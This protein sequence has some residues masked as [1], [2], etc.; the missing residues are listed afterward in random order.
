M[1][2]SFKNIWYTFSL[3]CNYFCTEFILF[4]IY[5]GWIFAQ[6]IESPGV[7]QKIC[8][9][10]YNESNIVDCT[11][12]EDGDVEDEIQ[13]R[14]AQWYLYT[15]LAYMFPA[16]FIDTILGSYADKYGRKFNIL[17][18][19]VGL[20]FIQ[21]FHI[22][23]LNPLINAPY[24]L[25]IP[26]SL[27]SGFTCYVNI[28]PS[29]C[30]AYLAD[31]ISDT[32]SLTIRSGIL[33]LFQ[34]IASALGGVCAAFV[35]TLWK[36]KQQPN[37]VRTFSIEPIHEENELNS[38]NKSFLNTFKNI[39]IDIKY[40]LINGWRTYTKKRSGN[41]RLFMWITGGALMLSY[42]TSVE[43]RISSVMNSYAFRRTDDNALDWDAQ[44]LGFWN[45]I[46]YGSL[47]VGTFIGV[48]VFKKILKFQETTL[49]IISLLSSS[50]RLFLIAFATTDLQMY[51]ANICG[52]FGSLIQPAT[53]SFI[54]QLVSLDEVGRAFA[55]FGIGSN[56]TFI[57]INL[58]FCSIYIMCESWMPGFLFLFIGVLQIIFVIALIWV[59]YQSKLEGISAIK[60]VR[61]N[62]AGNEQRP[63]M[64]IDVSSFI[65]RHFKV[66]QNEHNDN[67]D[68][69]VALTSLKKV[70]RNKLSQN[71]INE[72][73]SNIREENRSINKIST[74]LV[75]PN[76]YYERRASIITFC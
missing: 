9:I 28:I 19:I 4:F 8:Q 60:V 73:V 25:M 61:D 27:M 49:I 76:N 70:L 14:T 46:G 58:L 35:V 32:S 67:R 45:G 26:V 71:N 50:C 33:S 42:T 56:I 37:K 5:F 55:L 44:R 16:L 17:F 68:K 69:N 72:G 31:K 18:G 13:Q 62:T 2:Q 29:S 21:F 3:I 63:R 15:S 7:Y 40:L 38:S 30:N 47:I 11:L 57:L 39:I 48:F 43:T 51:L 54:S 65:N 75:N 6:S 24:W 23:I 34:L 66:T 22:I 20:G 59:H 36:I 74:N 64:S 52:C 53:V 10:Y 41:K 12:I 1:F